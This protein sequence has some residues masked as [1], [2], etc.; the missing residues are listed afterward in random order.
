MRLLIVSDVEIERGRG[1]VS[2]LLGSLPHLAR[3][4]EVVVA[5]LGCRDP[6][7]WHEI[8]HSRV[9]YYAL[10]FKLRGWF[11]E[12]LSEI[13]EEII[14]LAQARRPDLVVLYWEAWD[15]MDRL[16]LRLQEIGIPFATILHSIPFVDAPPRPTRFLWDL[17][18]RLFGEKD[19]RVSQYILLNAWNTGRVLRRLN[20]IVL[21]ETVSEYLGRYFPRL[22]F[23]TAYPGYAVDTS[24][25]DSIPPPPKIYDIAFMA[26]LV[27]EKGIFELL[28]ILVE[29]KQRGVDMRLLLIGSFESSFDE[30]QFLRKADELRVRSNLQLVGWVEGVHKYQLL[31]SAR[32]FVYPSL[33]S[34]TFSFCL[35]EALA[36][37]LPTICYDVPFTRRIYK[38]PAVRRVRLRD[39]RGFAKETAAIL[40]NGDVAALLGEEARRFSQHYSSWEDVTAAEIDAYRKLLQGCIDGPGRLSGH[41]QP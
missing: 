18:R 1:P 4:C 15:L 17:A 26:K 5:G 38:T 23:Y 24:F 40:E 41:I 35:L 31:K 21:N 9:E 13:V 14:L 30:S 34:D 2:R 28:D 8:D 32:L 16:S 19:L 10:P 22:N 20:A 25:I 7:Q 12:N 11:V 3:Q 27:P 37:G 29:I 36:C 33:S 6:R 39:H